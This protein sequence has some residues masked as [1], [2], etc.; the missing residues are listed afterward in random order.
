M[1]EPDHS[2][3]PWWIVTILTIGLIIYGAWPAHASEHDEVIAVETIALEAR[4][5]P[6][7]GQ[8]AIGEVIRQRMLERRQSVAEVVFQPKQFSCWN[9]M[10][11]ATETLR[12]LPPQVIQRA[13]RAWH[14]SASTSYARGANLYYNPR[15]AKPRW[16]NSRR[17]HE[18]AVIG[19]HRFMREDM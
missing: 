7:I 16:A 19:D 12:T 8:V 14:T 13:W 5:Q 17:V 2:N 15:L 3:L 1:N 11:E 4:N 9:S 10:W 18:T 6:F